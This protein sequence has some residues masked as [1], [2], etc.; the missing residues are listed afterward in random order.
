[1]GEPSPVV[2]PPPPCLVWCVPEV[3]GE[4][5][6]GEMGWR[7]PHGTGVG[8]GKSGERSSCHLLTRTVAK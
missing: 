1:M 2:V 4:E 5:G 6:G 3:G 8:G 7:G